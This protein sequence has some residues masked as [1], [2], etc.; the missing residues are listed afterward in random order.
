MKQES[1][2]TNARRA[3]NPEKYNAY[4]RKWR[5]KNGP[6]C[7][8]SRQ[9]RRYKPTRPEPKNCESCGTPFSQVTFGA[10]ID[11]NHTTGLFRGWLC[12]NCNLALG[13]LK[14][15]PERIF[16]LMQYLEGAE[17]LS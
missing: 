11:H 3:A 10:C 15:D 6:R 4:M 13:H 16:K 7:N 5:L 17:L 2:K 1:A 12:G 8:Q 9:Q 14:D